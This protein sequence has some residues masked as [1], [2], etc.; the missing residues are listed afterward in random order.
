[1]ADLRQLLRGLTVF[2]GEL[3]TFDPV[4][5]PDDPVEL[6]TAWLLGA[7]RAQVPEPHAMTLATADADGNPSARTLILKDV[8]AA[9]WRFAAHDDSAKGR[10]LSDRPYAALT[11][12]WQ[13][14]ARQVRVRGPVVREDAERSAA[15]FLARGAGARAEALVGRQSRPLASLAERDAAVADAA[16]RLARDPELVPAAWTLHTVRAESVEF[17]QG[18]EDRNHTRLAY[19]RS[20][21]G[22]TKELRWP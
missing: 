8:D 15:D 14:L 21:A 5:T 3:P 11:F 12:Y 16:A 10:E 22:W 17:W 6:F 2:G 1:M 7:I 4:A 19:R 13:P 20:G 9:G 18:A